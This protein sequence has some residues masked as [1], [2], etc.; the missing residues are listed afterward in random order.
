MPQ[1]ER[2]RLALGARR[3]AVV[4]DPTGSKRTAFAERQAPSAKR[5]LHTL[6]TFSLFGIFA[7]QAVAANATKPDVAVSKAEQV[8]PL[9]PAPPAPAPAPSTPATGERPISLDEAI[10]TAYRNHAD[11]TVSEENVEAAR[12]RVTQAKTGTLPV[13]TAGIAYTG[14]GVTD[15]GDIFGPGGP[16]TFVTDQGL[17]P[18]VRAR[19]TLYNG[20]QTRLQVRQAREN[21]TGSVA[22]A[23]NTRRLLKFTVTQNYIETL[24][25]QKQALLL[26]EQVR[27][28]QAQLDLINARIQVGD[29]AQ[30]DRYPLERELR[31]AQQR[32]IE[33]NNNVNVLATSL[34]NSMGLPA[35]PVIQ[36]ADLPTEPRFEVPSVEEAMTVAERTRPDLIQDKT[37]VEISRASVSLARIRRLPLLTA[38][39]GANVTP[40]N[41]ISHGDYSFALAVTMPIWD[42]NLTRSQQ[43]EA[44]AGLAANLARLE[45]TRKDVAAE[46][47]Q[48]LLNLAS[49]RER[50]DSSAA[51]VEAARVALEAANARYQQGLATTIDLTDAQVG[52]ILAGNNAIN[53]LYDYYESRAQLDRAIGR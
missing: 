26:Q 11:V 25:S 2:Q 53:A 24:R 48:A 32:N 17:Q 23:Q 15:L 49:T 19:W 42:A 45:Q 43:R 10:D 9:A 28:A 31:L 13:I 14:R 12:Q 22:G 37:A 30:A 34:R 38:D 1:P 8:Q 18:A 35:G 46:V 4:D 39:L 29:A 40:N 7:G 20:G 44:E 33:A 6:L 47:Q 41:Q 21:V 52:F 5:C 3:L 16:D 51:T 27:L 50:L 36:I